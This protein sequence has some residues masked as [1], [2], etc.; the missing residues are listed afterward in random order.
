[1]EGLPQVLRRFVLDEF[2]FEFEFAVALVADSA[3]R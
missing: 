2:E 1:V 3:R